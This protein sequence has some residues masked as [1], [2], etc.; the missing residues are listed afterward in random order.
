MSRLAFWTLS[1]LATRKRSKTASSSRYQ[2]HLSYVNP[3]S[4]SFLSSS[5]SSCILLVLGSGRLART[6]QRWLT[7][8]GLEAGV[9]AA[10]AG[11]GAGA[12]AAGFGAGAGIFRVMHDFALLRVDLTEQL[13]CE[14]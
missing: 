13:L 8:A 6:C 1:S 12:A 14:T 4:D 2:A 7:A 11:F 3:K 5:R 10:A 9:D